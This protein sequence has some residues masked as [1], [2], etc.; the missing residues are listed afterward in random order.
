M[1]TKRPLLFITDKQPPNTMEPETRALTFD[2]MYFKKPVTKYITP[3][4]SQ[5]SANYTQLSSGGQLPSSNGTSVTNQPNLSEN[6]FGKKPF[7]ERAGIFLEKNWG[8][9]ALGVGIIVIVSKVAYDKHQKKKEAD[10]AMRIEKENACKIKMEKLISDHKKLQE[11]KR[12][13]SNPT[14]SPINEALQKV[15]PVSSPTNSPIN[16][17]LQK[18]T[19][20]IQPE[21]SSPKVTDAPSDHKAQS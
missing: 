11:A 4:A 5:T 8:W 17:A 10:A 14:G 7:M 3:P 16:E 6:V 9:V 20:A 19:P 15:T 21:E 13:E 12:K 2:E 18:V 1:L